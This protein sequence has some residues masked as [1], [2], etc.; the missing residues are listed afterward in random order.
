[1]SNPFFKNHG[2][3]KISEIIKLLHIN[4]NDQYKDQEIQDIKDLSSSII[5]T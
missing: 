5:M 1:M 4:I 3:I 2:P